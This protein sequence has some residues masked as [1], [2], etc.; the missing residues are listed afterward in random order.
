MRES[1]NYCENLKCR[2][3]TEWVA[4]DV[5]YF[6][7]TDSTNLQA[8]LAAEQGA[9]HGTLLVAESQTAGRGR[10]GRSWNS[11]AEGNLY[12]SLLLKP[13]FSV[14][15]A[16]MVT[17]VMGLA[18]AETIR[19]KCEL[20]ALIKWPNDVVVNGKKVCGI[21]TELGLNGNAIDDLVV[22]VGINVGQRE[23]ALEIASTATGLVIEAGGEV[24]R[25]ELL[26]GV[27]Q[28]FETLYEVFAGDGN[29]RSL[30]ERYDELLINKGR[31]VRVLDPREEYTGVASGITEMGE[32]LVE[33]PGGEVEKVYA[34]EVSVRGIYGYV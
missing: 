12:F 14:E 33:K 4:K 21:L 32:L 1:E 2:L 31:E 5:R 25:E 15:I 9:L 13:D 11:D 34:G 26:A 23:F 19:E 6:M 10:R 20:D 8:R 7:E 3:S 30:R 27:L 29:L 22:G 24:D 28:R 18:V 17:L 16:S